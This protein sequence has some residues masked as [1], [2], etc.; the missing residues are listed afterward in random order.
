MRILK[1]V[2]VVSLLGLF[3]TACAAPKHKLKATQESNP[4]TA[5]TTDPESPG[6]FWRQEYQRN[7]TV[8]PQTTPKVKKKIVPGKDPVT[9][10]KQ[11]EGLHAFKDRSVLRGLMNI[12]PAR[13]AW[14]A[15]FVNAILDKVDVEGTDS[16]QARSFLNWGIETRAP[17]EGDVV[18]FAR[19]RSREAGHVGFYV[20]EEVVDGVRYILVLGGNQRKA[21]N[22]AYYPARYVLGYRTF[23]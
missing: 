17:K 3:T 5:Y 14:C 23:G 13:I 6:A 12:D 15:G 18:V 11:Y 2:I 21:V 1:T 7:Q 22:V 16:L 10:A 8:V 4:V 9:V 20:G 19:G